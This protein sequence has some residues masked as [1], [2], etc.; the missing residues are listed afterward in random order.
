[1][2]ETFKNDR[3]VSKAGR[4]FKTLKETL[5]YT[6]NELETRRGAQS[7]PLKKQVVFDEGGW[8]KGA[9][10]DEDGPRVFFCLEKALVAGPY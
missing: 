5:M 10:N 1:M 6:E 7:E 8:A 9:I 3:K 4:S 2:G